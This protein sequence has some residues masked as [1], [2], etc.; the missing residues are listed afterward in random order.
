MKLQQSPKRNRLQVAGGK[1]W[2]FWRAAAEEKRGRRSSTR[3]RRAAYAKERD[4]RAREAI[5]RQRSRR[6]Q[7]VVDFVD[8]FGQLVRARWPTLLLAAQRLV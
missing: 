4:K 2:P 8:N 6:S 5:S 7:L 3:Q 1:E